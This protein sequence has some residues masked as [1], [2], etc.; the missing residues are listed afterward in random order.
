MVIVR[1]MYEITELV[2][3]CIGSVGLYMA[4][5]NVLPL[6][7]VPDFPAALFVLSSVVVMHHVRV[8]TYPPVQKLWRL[9]LELVGLYIATQVLVALIWEQFHALL[10]VSRDAVLNTNLGLVFLK[11]FPRLIMFV[12]QDVCYFAQLVLSVMVTIKA[13][14]YTRSL[15]YVLPERRIYQYYE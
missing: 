2:A 11:H 3:G 15:D 9:L 13:V 6:K 12:R 1:G 8:V 4:G 5:C 10:D 7:Y 14:A